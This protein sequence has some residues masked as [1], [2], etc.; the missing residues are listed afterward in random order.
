MQK[1]IE[2]RYAIK[3]CVKLDETASETFKKLQK[4]YGDEVLSQAQVFRWHK[5]FKE[6]REHV[7]DEQRSGR[8]STSRTDEN[9]ERVRILVDKDRR[10]TVRFIANELELNKNTVNQILNEELGM[11]KICAK[12]VPK[13]LTVEQKENR[14]HTCQELLD[15]LEGEPDFMDRVITGDESWVFEYDPPFRDSGQHSRC[16]NRC[17]EGPDTRRLPTLLPRVG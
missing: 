5:M 14:L 16:C 12:M 8:P 7:E 3:F 2:Q 1:N 13:N 4:A 9:V 10:V 6:G 17:F 15:R 11:R